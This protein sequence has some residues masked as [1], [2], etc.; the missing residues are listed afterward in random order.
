M[1]GTG[2]ACDPLILST[3]MSTD[4]VG[5]AIRL[6]TDLDA[7][8]T[9]LSID[10]VGAYDHVLRQAMLSGLNAVPEARAMLPFVRMAYASLSRYAWED[11]GGA[12]RFVEQAEGG[13]QGDPLMPM[14]FS[15]AVHEALDRAQA[16]LQPGEHIFAFLDDVYALCAPERVREVYNCLERHLTSVAGIWLHQG[17]TRVWNRAGLRPPNLEDLGRDVWSPEGIKV[18]GTPVGNADYVRGLL[19]ER[20]KEERKLWESIPFVCDP[21]CAWQLVIQCAMS[22]ATHVLRTVPPSLV[23]DYAQVHDDGVWLA[24]S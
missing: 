4:S 20:L 21:Q 24:A 5:H 1:S 22:M 8:L 14:L 12:F 23:G 2:P 17:K 13:E 10:G 15:L 7:R 11:G 18:L 16:E 3:R 19:S 6:T 9:V